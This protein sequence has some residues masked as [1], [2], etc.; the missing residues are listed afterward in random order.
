MLIRGAVASGVSGGVVGGV[1]SGILGGVA[2]G[3]AGGVSTGVT[4]QPDPPQRIRV[5]G[6][7]Q[8][9]NLLIKVQPAYPPLAK[10]SRIQGVVSLATVISKDG[11][12]QNLQVISG[13]PMLV[14]AALEAVKQWT[15]KPTLLNGQPVEV[16]TQIDVNFTLSEQ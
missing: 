11:T 10:Q 15:Y 5:G 8:S 9:A 7:V 14:K 6:N 4:P 2:G 13:H 1:S 3:V 16:I 12:I